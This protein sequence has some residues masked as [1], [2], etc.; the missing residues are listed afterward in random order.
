MCLQCRDD[1]AANGR[2]WGERL[3]VLSAPRPSIKHLPVGLFRRASWNFGG[4]DRQ[5]QSRETRAHKDAGCEQSPQPAMFPPH[6]ER[7]HKLGVLGAEPTEKTGP[8]AVE[9]VEEGTD[10]RGPAALTHID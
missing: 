9:L 8:E 4:R 3:G 1:T 5:R 6:G 2:D 7:G 10:R